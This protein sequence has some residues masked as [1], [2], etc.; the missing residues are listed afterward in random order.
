MAPD[1]SRMTDGDAD[2]VRRRF[3]VFMLNGFG[4]QPYGKRD[5]L[6]NGS[7]LTTRWVALFWIPVIPLDTFRVRKRERRFWWTTYDVLSVS[8][9]DMK[10]VS[11]V[12]GF[13]V[14]LL[15][16]MLLTRN[17]PAWAGWSAGLAWMCLPF[18]LRS[19]ALRRPDLRT[20]DGGEP[21]L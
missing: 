8:K 7:Y 19:R 20:R 17:W 3:R 2:G 4:T 6:P 18:L 12:Y 14:G 16:L 13:I 11:N 15:G 9:P 10:Q 1:Y 21:R 5:F